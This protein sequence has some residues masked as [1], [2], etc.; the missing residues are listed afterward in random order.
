MKILFV[1]HTAASS[2]AELALM[3]LI[4]APSLDAWW[5]YVCQTS[6]GVNEAVRNLS[7]AE[8]YMLRDLFDAGYAPYVGD[9]DSLKLP[10]L[11]LVA[12]ATA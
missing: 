1:N 3:R 11:A 2:G 4:E 9:D 8:H 7:P 6:P 5:E 12:A 10:G